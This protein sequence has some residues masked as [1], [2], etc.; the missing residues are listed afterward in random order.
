MS[1]GIQRE[2]FQFHAALGGPQL[3]SLADSLSH[4]Q[5]VQLVLHR[6]SKTHQL[7]AVPQQLPRVPLFWGGNPDARETI[8]EQQFQ[9]VPG[10]PRVGLLLTNRPRANLGGVAHP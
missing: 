1:P 9:K 7:E 6:G 2:S 8:A 3:F 10:I 5:S 4:G